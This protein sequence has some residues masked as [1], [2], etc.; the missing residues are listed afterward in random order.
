MR[1]PKLVIFDMD[2]LIFDSERLF[3]RE[4]KKV[5]KDYGYEL[6]EKKYIQLLGLNS[7]F[8]KEEMLA[9]YGENYPIEETSLKARE[10]FN[11]CA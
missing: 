7:N 5:M 6:T 3:M 9:M 8:L 11:V 2:G 1:K 10:N 4:L